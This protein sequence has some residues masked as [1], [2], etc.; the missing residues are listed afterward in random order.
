MRM[1]ECSIFSKY[2]KMENIYVLSI[3]IAIVHFIIKYIE[4]NVIKKDEI[5]L[6]TM[7]RDS[8]IVFIAS[9]IGFFLMDQLTPM[10]NE[11]AKMSGRGSVAFT[12]NPNF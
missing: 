11:T 9:V 7:V 6:K 8:I 4:R 2:N 3:T 1:V 5:A 10:L 12:D